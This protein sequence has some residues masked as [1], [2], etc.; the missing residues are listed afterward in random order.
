MLMKQIIAMAGTHISQVIPSLRS[1][2]YVP[3]LLC[4]LTSPTTEDKNNRL[5]Q[6]I[7]SHVP[8]CMVSDPRKP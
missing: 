6:N 3:C 5:L 2:N 8:Q 7:G 1:V 4:Q